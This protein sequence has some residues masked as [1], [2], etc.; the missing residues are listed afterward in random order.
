M[1]ALILISAIIGI[2]ALMIA[3]ILYAYRFVLKRNKIAMVYSYEEKDEDRATN[4][5]YFLKNDGLLDGVD[6]FIVIHGECSVPLPKRR[7]VVYIK[8]ET[9]TVS[10]FEPFYYALKEYVKK[11]YDYYFFMNSSMR[12]PYVSKPYTWVDHFVPLFGKETKLV[13]TAIECV[14]KSGRYAPYLQAGFF[15]LDREGLM[16]LQDIGFFQ[17]GK[18]ELMSQKILGGNEEWT[19][20]SLVSE[21]CSRRTVVPENEVFIKI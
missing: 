15:G 2:C 9:G 21:C 18:E 8:R 19:Y 4:L 1:K 17:E 14:D 10:A 11:S 6:Y 20:A 16:Y 7:N 13:G 5:E 3:G 12:G